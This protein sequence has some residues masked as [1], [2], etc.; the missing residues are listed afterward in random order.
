M[1]KNKQKH[2]ME[3]EVLEELEHEHLESHSRS[4]GFECLRAHRNELQGSFRF[5]GFGCCVIRTHKTSLFGSFCF[6][7]VR[8]DLCFFPAG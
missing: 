5:L 7:K 2:K 1:Q 3:V 8:N 4:R 6:G